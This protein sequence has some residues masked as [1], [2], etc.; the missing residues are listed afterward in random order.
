MREHTST[1]DEDGIAAVIH[2]VNVSTGLDEVR[3]TSQRLRY[4]RPNSPQSGGADEKVVC[5][6]T[7]LLIS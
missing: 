2:S 7:L 6:R 3:L 5:L 4:D 1:H